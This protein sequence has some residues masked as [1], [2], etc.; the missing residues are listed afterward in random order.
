MA[1]TLAQ[2]L[3]NAGSVN[4]AR[5]FRRMQDKLLGWDVRV[6]NAG[7][8]TTGLGNGGVA[9]Y[10]GA[11]TTGDLAVVQRGA[12]ANMSVDVGAGFAMVGGTES[13]TQGEYGAYNDATVNVTIS[14]SDPTNPRI[15]VIGIRI[16]DTEYSGANNDAA[17]IVVT[18]TPAGAPVVP[19]L[20]ADFLSLAHVAVAAL[21]ATIVTGNITDKRRNLASL[22]GVAV[23][24][25][26]AGYPTVNLW[27]GMVT[28]D[29]AIDCLLVYSGAAWMQIGPLS[30]WTAFT[31]AL[32]N[33]AIGNGTLSCAYMRVGR[34]IDYRI[35]LKWGTTTSASG[36]QIFALPVAPHAAYVQ[37]WAVGNGLVVAAGGGYGGYSAVMPTG[38]ATLALLGLSGG[39]VNATVPAVFTTN[40][41]L[42]ILGTYEAAA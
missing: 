37:N 33:I 14:A 10:Y 9:R 22:G 26:S 21:A 15:D 34:F 7:L 1:L 31:P 19:T 30:G 25:S 35:N 13:A 16:R 2:F 39:Y 29:R 41:N 20:P 17:I 8:A 4:H 23:C 11:G 38:S 6:P 36:T 12:G 24:D 27:E 32:T 28:Y 40:D 42:S 5:D 3:E 18:G